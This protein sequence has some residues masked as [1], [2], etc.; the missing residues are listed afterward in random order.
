MNGYG[1]HLRCTAKM[2]IVTQ[3]T[4]KKLCS[5]M[6]LPVPRNCAKRS[7]TRPNASESSR[8]SRRRRSRGWSSRDLVRVISVTLV[9]PSVVLVAPVFGQQVVQDVVHGDGAE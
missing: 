7:E 9:H 2:F 4:T 3:T 8:G 1:S 6:K 5:R